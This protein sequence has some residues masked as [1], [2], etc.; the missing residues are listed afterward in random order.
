MAKTK[1]DPTS[2]TKALG[3]LLLI[4]AALA[5][6]G[7]LISWTTGAIDLPTLISSLIALALLIYLCTHL[8]YSAR[9]GTQ[10]TPPKTTQPTP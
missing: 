7:T 10:K 4:L 6:L 1:K 3:I 2:L 5:I 9:T 8:L